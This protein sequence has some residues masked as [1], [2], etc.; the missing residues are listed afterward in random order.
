MK[1]DILQMQKKKCVGGL[2]PQMILS[3][4]KLKSCKSTK[5]KIALN[6]DTDD[7]TD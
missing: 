5:R 4:I 7:G 2:R 3:V 6:Y 1:G